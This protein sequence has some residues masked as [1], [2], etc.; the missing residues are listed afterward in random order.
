M[1]SLGRISRCRSSPA[2]ACKLPEMSISLPLLAAGKLALQCPRALLSKSNAACQGPE[3]AL[4]ACCIVSMRSQTA[5]EFKRSWE[6][7]FFVS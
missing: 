3:S 1:T 4:I 2:E 6:D 7:A 5:E